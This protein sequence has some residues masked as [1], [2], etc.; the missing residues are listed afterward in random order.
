M[1]NDVPE[2]VPS[3]LPRALQ[4]FANG[5]YRI[6]TAALTLSLFGAGV[7]IVAVVFEI[8]AIGGSP[9]DVSVVATGGA[10][11]ML[12][13][14]L[15]GGVAADRIPQKRILATVEATKT[16]AIAAAAT[17]AISGAV[18]L[19]HLA[20]VAF[21]LGVADG[22]FYPAYSALLPSVLP[23]DQL[24]AANGVE[25]MLRPVIANA[26]GP[27]IASAAIAVWSPAI[28]FWIVAIAQ[29]LATVGLL[30]LRTTPVRREADAVPQHPI[31]AIFSDIQG[32]F[33]YM[34]RTPWLLATLLFACL[35]ILVL[36]GPIEVLLPFAVKDQVPVAVQLL[37]GDNNG[38]G[39]FALALAAFGL[40]G[41]IGSF[42]VASAKLP[43]RYLTIM[44][45]LW[46]AG[47]LPLLVIGI[48]DQL[49]L[50]IIALVLVGFAFSAANVIWGTLLQRRVPAE[51]LGRVSSLDF[52]VSLAL[53][54][55]SM[56]IAGP[57]GEAI[58]L[59]PA[60]IAAGVI[61]VFLAVAA[62]LIARMPKDELEHPLDTAPPAAEP[63]EAPPLDVDASRAEVSGAE[64]LDVERPGA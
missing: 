1:T 22:F 4:P 39:A 63:L 37:F 9:I 55:V 10:I 17:L 61:P 19:W 27:A 16:V 64:R 46:G 48:T 23:A 6:L 15:L 42:V 25:G 24:L 60:F 40:G 58:G 45:V 33:V 38:A 57:V 2:A 28:A 62:I 11:G 31:K 52:F 43:R 14:V 29:A 26:A 18:E 8:I 7:W 12:L 51:L 20:V 21:V 32:G 59:A 49:W 50:M 35:L 41:A 53:M 30:F 34:I 56:A 47:C 54:P 5:Q 36:M 44:N 13:A 3:R